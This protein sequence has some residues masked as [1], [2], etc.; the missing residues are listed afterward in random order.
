[1]FFLFSRC[2]RLQEIYRTTKVVSP[3]NDVA[4]LKYESAL[5]RWRYRCLALR[6]CLP[7]SRF[8]PILHSSHDQATDLR[9]ARG[10]RE[11]VCG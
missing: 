5:L 2:L 1:M 9:T 8:D 4:L 6:Y 7:Q 3:T 11:R 10:G